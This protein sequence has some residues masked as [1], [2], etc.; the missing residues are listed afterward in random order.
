M[1][2]SDGDRALS[3]DEFLAGTSSRF[4]TLDADG[5][6]EVTSAEIL[7]ARDGA[8]EERARRMIERFDADGNGSVSLDEMEARASERFARIDRNDDG[9]LE[10]RELRRGFRGGDRDERGGPRRGVDQPTQRDL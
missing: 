7:A 8:R 10:P 1:L 5:N 9:S 2:D 3:L 4:E 6:G